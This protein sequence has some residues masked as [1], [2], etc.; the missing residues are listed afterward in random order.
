MGEMI[1]D[2]ARKRW[3]CCCRQGAEIELNL[4]W[5]PP[6]GPDKMGEHATQIFWLGLSL[7]EIQSL[8]AVCALKNL[9]C[10]SPAGGA[11]IFCIRFI[12]HSMIRYPFILRYIRMNGAVVASS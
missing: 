1:L 3:Q 9:V 2:N 7:P 6:W 12:E 8:A 4:V 10:L 11:T 5:E